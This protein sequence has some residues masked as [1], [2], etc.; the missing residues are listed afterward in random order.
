M[1]AVPS[2]RFANRP[3][4]VAGTN[5]I[6]RF[7]RFG[8]STHAQ[9][10]RLRR[11]HLA[12]AI[13]RAKRCCL[14]LVRTRSA[15]GKED[16]GA[17]YL[18]CASPGTDAQHDVV[19][20]VAPP[21]EAEVDGYSFFVRNFHSLSK[22]GFIPAHPD[23]FDGFVPAVS[24]HAAGALS[25]LTRCARSQLTAFDSRALDKTWFGLLSQ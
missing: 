16:F 22:T 6:S 8:F 2:E 9:G 23:P 11:V 12:L 4:T 13:S 5:G 18:A 17:Q 10:L 24:I 15:H 1:S 7:S 21:P 20:A 14:P 19:T 25:T 3:T